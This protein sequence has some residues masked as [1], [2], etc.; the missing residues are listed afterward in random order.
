M[1]EEPQTPTQAEPKESEIQ[2]IPPDFYGGLKKAPRASVAQAAAFR[3]PLV[4][5]TRKAPSPANIAPPSAL[6]A[7][8]AGKGSVIKRLPPKVIIILSSGIFALILAGISYY[9]IRQARTIKQS[10]QSSAQTGNVPQTEIT[11]LAATSTTEIASTVVSTSSVST[12]QPLIG[13]IFPP[14][15]YT[16]TIDADNDGLT[17]IEETLYGTDSNKPDSDVDGFIDGL[18]VVNL[19]NPLGFKPVRLIDSGRVNGYLNPSFGYSLYYPGLWTAQSLD[20]TNAQV[21]FSSGA[22]DYVEVVEVDNS[23]KL[24][25]MDWYKGQSPGAQTSDLKPF[26]TKDKVEGVLSPDGLTAYLP[27]GS[28][29][30]VI[31]YNIGLKDQVSFLQTFMMMITSF[32]FPGVAEHPVFGA[33]SGIETTPTQASSITTSSPFGAVTP[34]P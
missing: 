1:S 11:P 8:M 3:Q 20:S 19:Y 24:P 21:L 18:E 12:I 9:Y 29:I 10:V 16:Q 26:I 25:L 28:T 5:Q 31:T 15:T 30:Y 4:A 2:T 33:S 13:V 23:L 6:P 14:K 17:D 34:I 27:F 22:G 32:R 7:T